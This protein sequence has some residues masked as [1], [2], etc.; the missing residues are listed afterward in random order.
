MNE[1]MRSTETA[2]DEQDE[3]EARPEGDNGVVGMLVARSAADGPFEWVLHVFMR[4]S[5][6]ACLVAWVVDCLCGRVLGC[7]LLWRFHCSFA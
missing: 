5:L 4:W 1:C 7:L 3:E 2:T 6:W